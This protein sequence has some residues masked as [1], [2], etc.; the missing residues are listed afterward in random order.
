MKEEG[1][2]FIIGPRIGLSV[3][4]FISGILFFVLLLD[5]HYKMIKTD[6]INNALGVKG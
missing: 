3:C 4:Y 6:I 1:E 2:S 5:S